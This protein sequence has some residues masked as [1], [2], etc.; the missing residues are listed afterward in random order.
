MT[1]FTEEA[2][3]IRN[4]ARNVRLRILVWGPGKPEPT[5]SPRERLGYEKRCQIKEVLRDSFK[6]AEVYFSEDPEME[7][8][9][10]DIEDKLLKEAL[11]ASASDLIVILAISRGSELELDYFVPTYPWIRDKIHVFLPKRYVSPPSN[12]L[13]SEVFKYLRP[14]QVEGYTDSEFKRCKVATEKAVRV[15]DTFALR[16]ILSQP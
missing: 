15:A 4:R 14:E 1:Y 8:I 9:G 13:V 2:D 7:A 12:G 16:K 3:D 5:A 11:Q 10:A 6:N